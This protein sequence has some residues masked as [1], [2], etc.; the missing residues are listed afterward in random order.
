MRRTKEGWLLLLILASVA[1]PEGLAA[2]DRRGA[3]AIVGKKDGRAL[4]GELIAVKKE[5]ILLKESWSSY[6]VSISR[7]DIASIKVKK[8]SGAVSGAFLGTLVGGLTGMAIG[9]KAGES[10]HSL[11]NFETAGTVIG[12]VIGAVIGGGA[13][14]WIGTSIKEYETFDLEHTAPEEIPL[15]LGR[16]RSRARFPDQI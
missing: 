10:H 11:V 13:G 16:L 3:D 5:S 1:L 8:G 12:A 2:K 9:R 7:S 6:D 4:R 15:T 14:L